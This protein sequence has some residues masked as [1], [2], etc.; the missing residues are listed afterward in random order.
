MVKKPLVTLILWIF[1][2]LPWYSLL[3]SNTSSGLSGPWSHPAPYF[4]LSILCCHWVKTLP[5]VNKIFKGGK[6]VKYKLKIITIL[7]KSSPPF[8][9]WVLSHFIPFYHWD[10]T[11]SCVH[12]PFRWRH[13]WEIYTKTVI[14]VKLLV[15]PNL[16]FKF[17]PTLLYFMYLILRLALGVG[18]DDGRERTDPTSQHRPKANRFCLLQ[19]R[20]QITTKLVNSWRLNKARTAGNKDDYTARVGRCSQ[21]T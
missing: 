13:V 10:K 3:T 17:Y 21:T 5:Y 12:K 14:N 9:M 6:H 4:T 15:S 19:T 18:D 7:K 2:G 8:V 16:C 20:G 11:I 1:S